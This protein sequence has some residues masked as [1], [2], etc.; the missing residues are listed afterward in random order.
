MRPAVSCACEAG[1]A[2]GPL[3]EL[4]P[5]PAARATG[6]PL[7][8]RGVAQPREGGRVQVLQACPRLAGLPVL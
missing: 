8:A 5:G 2:P 1:P 7:D 6:A 3:R 4:P